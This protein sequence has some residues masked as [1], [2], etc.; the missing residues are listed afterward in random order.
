MIEVCDLDEY[1]IVKARFKSM[2]TLKI[3]T[4]SSVVNK[5]GSQDKLNLLTKV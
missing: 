1:S 3:S 2:G 5:N 4:G